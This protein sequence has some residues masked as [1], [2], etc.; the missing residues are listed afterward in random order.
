MAANGGKLP[1]AT[2]SW[3]GG[4][5]SALLERPPS[6]GTPPCGPLDRHAIHAAAKRNETATAQE[7]R[8]LADL[9]AE[10]LESAD[11]SARYDDEL[12]KALAS[13]VV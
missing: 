6:S 13:K 5:K 2:A 12:R 11:R 10:F 1:D 7:P 4:L 9:K 8:R 3:G